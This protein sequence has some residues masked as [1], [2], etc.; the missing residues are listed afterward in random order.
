MKWFFDYWRALEPFQRVM[1]VLWLV[2]LLVMIAILV[3]LI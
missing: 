1:F 2:A 3:R